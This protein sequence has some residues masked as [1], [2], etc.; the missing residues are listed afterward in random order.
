VS[1]ISAKTFDILCDHSAITRAP[2]TA[3]VA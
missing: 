1:N 3:A 2:L